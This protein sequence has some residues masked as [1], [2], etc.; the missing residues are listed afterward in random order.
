MIS[1]DHNSARPIYEKLVEIDADDKM[2]WYALGETYYHRDKQ[3]ADEREKYLKKAD[4]AFKQALDLDPE[5]SVARIHVVHMQIM[6]GEYQNLIDDEKKYFQHNF[7]SYENLITTY[8]IMEDSI[9]ARKL[10]EDFRLV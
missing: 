2:S 5:F 7:D 8:E 9:N 1:G 4:S 10:L 6:A 3:D